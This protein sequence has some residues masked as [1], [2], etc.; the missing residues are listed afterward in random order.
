MYPKRSQRY[1]T[2]FRQAIY[3]K[4]IIF[5]QRWSYR[6]GSH[7][8]WEHIC[9]MRL[10]MLSLSLCIYITLSEEHSFFIK[11][12]LSVYKLSCRHRPPP[13][14]RNSIF[15]VVLQLGHIM[16]SW[17]HS[18]NSPSKRKGWIYKN[19]THG[20][21]DTRTHAALYIYRLELFPRRIQK[22]NI[23]GSLSDINLFLRLASSGFSAT[24]LKGFLF[25]LW[26][27]LM[28]I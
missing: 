4:K 12:I 9:F 19:L 25:V 20:R 17:H 8:K 22:N 2:P 5:G 28:N 11:E 15:V 27:D 16:F 10:Q 18:K 6:Q 24:D 14:M 3:L 7:L 13:H 23:P 26:R 1:G 21:T